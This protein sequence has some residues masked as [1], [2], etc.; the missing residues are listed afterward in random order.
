[1]LKNNAKTIIAVDKILT[2]AIY[3]FYPA[4]IVYLAVSCRGNWMTELMPYIVVP[5]VSFV[6]VSIFRHLYNAPRPYDEPGAP[7]PI[8]KKD[9][10]GKSFPSRH[11]FSIF[12]IAVT[13]FMVQPVSGILIGIAGVILAIIRVAGGVHYPRDVIAGA[14]IGV[15]LGLIGYAIL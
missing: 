1:M 14:I 5:G 8:I 3:I 10:P 13:A 6:L 15:A 4:L 7:E 2:T 12:I 11:V 9:S